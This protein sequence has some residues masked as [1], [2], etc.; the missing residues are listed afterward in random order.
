M[1][2][3][4]DAQRFLDGVAGSPPLDTQTAEQNR[5]DLAAAIP[6]T[7]DRHDVSKV[8]NTVIAGVPVRVYYPVAS[9]SPLPAFIFIHG[10]GWTI[11]DLELADT[12]VRDIALEAGAVGISIDYRLAP[13]HPFPA[14]LDDALSVTR[15]VLDGSSGLSIDPNRVAVAGDSAGGNLSAVISQEL[16]GQQPALVHQVLVYPVTDASR[17]DTPS[18]R[19]FA[20]GHFLTGRDLRYFYD[21]Y[22]GS[23][24]RAD[25]RISPALNPDLA[26]LPPATVITGECDPLRDEGEAYA[27][28]MMAAG[29][30]VTAVRFKGQVH[31]FVYIGG[32]ISDA[33]VARRFIGNQLKTALVTSSEAA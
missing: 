15:A 4:P 10:G 3:H 31:P 24:D 20:E 18:H 25:L 8:E 5:V 22:T 6:L 23:A 13:E 9:S 29:N 7:G 28:A 16:R 19:D 21:A 14:A 26:G 17:M 11:G 2:V 33:N 12:T 30:Q 27:Q 1:A 32:V